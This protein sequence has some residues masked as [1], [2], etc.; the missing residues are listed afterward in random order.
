MISPPT[1][2]TILTN[3][4]L[5]IQGAG[6]L[7]DLIKVNKAQA[8]QPDPPMS[9]DGL[10]EGLE[11]LEQRLDATDES[12]IEQ[13]KLIE[14]LA[15]QNASLAESLNKIYTRINLITIFSTIA[16]TLGLVAILLYL[17]QT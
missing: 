3:A 5:I 12:N 6:K 14:E 13:I 16:I 9:L 10:H 17:T 15:R 11:N 2:R 4:P 1:I 8:E 7:I